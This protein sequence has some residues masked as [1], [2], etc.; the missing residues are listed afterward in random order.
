VESFAC[1]G[2]ASH[3]RKRN[4]QLKGGMS[5]PIKHPL[6][7][8]AVH[9]RDACSYRKAP[10]FREHRGSNHCNTSFLSLLS[11]CSL[12]GRTSSFFHQSSKVPPRGRITIRCSGLSGRIFSSG[13]PG[14]GS[15]ACRL[16]DSICRR[17]TH[18]DGGIS[19]GHYIAKSDA[20]ASELR[21]AALDHKPVIFGASVIP[22]QISHREFLKGRHT[23]ALAWQASLNSRIM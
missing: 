10:W 15:Y 18:P 13:L 3:P 16:Q 19:L 9:I 6:P 14:S 22:L 20:M 8:S 4:H 2:R 1:K 21:M 7:R 17:S 5:H 23:M 11:S 12:D